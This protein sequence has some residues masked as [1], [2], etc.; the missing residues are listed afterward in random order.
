MS[1]ALGTERTPLTMSSSCAGQNEP[2]SRYVVKRQCRSRGME[3]TSPYCSDDLV[4]FQQGRGR[5]LCLRRQLSLTNLFFETVGCSV[6]R[7]AQQPPVRLPSDRPATSG[8][9][10]SQG[11]K[12]H[13]PPRGPSLEKPSLAS[14]EDQAAICSTV[15]NTTEGRPFLASTGQDLASPVG[16]VEPSCI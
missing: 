1:P 2:R 16:N 12:V 15:V 3:A 5:P 10:A 8:F 4:S 13:S 6:P 11:H 14:G 9:Q 7:L